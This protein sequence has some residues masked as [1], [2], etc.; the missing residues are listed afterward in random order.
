MLFPEADAHLDAIHSGHHPVQ[1]DQIDGPAL[2]LLQRFLAVCRLQDIVSFIF[3]VKP[4]QFP[5]LPVVI[6]DQH[7]GRAFH[8]RSPPLVNPPIGNG[9]ES[10]S[11]FR[12]SAY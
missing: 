9:C 11:S 5:D 2:H 7:G 4:D 6:H 8:G 12:S 1:N 10:P 3:Q